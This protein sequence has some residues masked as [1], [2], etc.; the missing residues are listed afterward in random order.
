[1][2]RFVDEYGIGMV[3]PDFE[4]ASLAA[5]LEALT[6]ERVAEWKSASDVHAELLSSESQAAIWDDLVAR[7]TSSGRAG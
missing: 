2:A 3:L 4:P 6:P 1:M 7:V 5:A